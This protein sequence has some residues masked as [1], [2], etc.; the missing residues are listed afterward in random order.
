MTDDP[1]LTCPHQTKGACETCREA[2][3]QMEREEKA[4]WFMV[5]GLFVLNIGW[6]GVVVWAVI[7]MVNWF[8]GQ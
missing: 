6:I 2:A 1:D 8:T 7:K 4:I 5:I 3:K